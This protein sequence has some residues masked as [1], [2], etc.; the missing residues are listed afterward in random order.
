[1]NPSDDLSDLLQSWQPEPTV[2]RDF[3]RGVWSRIESTEIKG[4]T[5]FFAF[6]NWIQ[7]FAC[8]RIALSAAM[9]ALFAGVFLGGIQA[10]SSQ[11][12]RYLQSLNPY[13]FHSH[14]R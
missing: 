1:M 9:L 13:G 12:D 5:P 4:G 2:P 7:F 6:F 3:N 11:E 10:R 8:P 14:S